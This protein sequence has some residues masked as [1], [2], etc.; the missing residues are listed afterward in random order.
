MF[1]QVG[2]QAINMDHVDLVTFWE[3]GEVTLAFSGDDNSYIRL[4]GDRAEAF[5]AWWEERADVYKCPSV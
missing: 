2:N 4:E 1:V 5:R 3:N